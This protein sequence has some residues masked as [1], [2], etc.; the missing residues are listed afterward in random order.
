M[1]S[2]EL[3]KKMEIEC[4]P[5]AQVSRPRR[6]RIIKLEERIAPKKGGVHGGKKTW[7]C[8]YGTADTCCC[9]ADN[10]LVW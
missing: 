5:D 10:S 4:L 1:E 2:H 8:G 3:Q 9:G 7:D 6:F